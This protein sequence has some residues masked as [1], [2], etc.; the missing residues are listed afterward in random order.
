MIWIS[1]VPFGHIRTCVQ[2]R[3]LSNK[4]SYDVEKLI[5]YLKQIEKMDYKKVFKLWDNVPQWQKWMEI[6]Q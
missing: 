3:Y 2:I 6:E 4:F 5:L 1:T